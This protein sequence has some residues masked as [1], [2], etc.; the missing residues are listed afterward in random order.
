MS[1]AV[2]PL[3]T[4]RAHASPATRADWAHDRLRAA[5]LSGELQPGAKLLVQELAARWSVSPT[6]LREALARL[7]AAGLVELTA[8]RGARVPEMSAAEAVEL[9]ELRLLL[10]PRALRQSLRAS[11]AAH[12]AAVDAA[13]RR[14]EAASRADP[15]DAA[16]LAGAHVGFHAE[17]LARCPSA[18]MRRTV[19][20]LAE[21]AQRYQHLAVLD[22]KRYRA[23]ERDHAALRAAAMAGDVARASR[24]L[25]RHLEGTLATAKDVL[26]RERRERD[27]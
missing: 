18:W 4:A 8:Q 11:D 17:L 9:Y 24:L 22:P 15:I 3:A 21:H 16:E 25:V 1:A 12:R 10:E 5:I 19:G 6:P 27:G 20:L 23:S 7:G 13:W 26:E 14:L 2:K